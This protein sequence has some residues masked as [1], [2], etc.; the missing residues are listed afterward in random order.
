MV[1]QDSSP[2]QSSPLQKCRLPDS[3]CGVRNLSPVLPLP[4]WSSSCVTLNKFLTFSMPQFSHPQV[5]T[6]FNSYSCS[7]NLLRQRNK[8]LNP[9]PVT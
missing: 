9:V 1:A 6:E 8:A 2:P 3:T 7:E 4:Y 5:K